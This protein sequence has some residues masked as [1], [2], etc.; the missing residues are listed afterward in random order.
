MRSNAYF[1]NAI[2]NPSAFTFLSKTGNALCVPCFWRRLRDSLLSS[3][4]QNSPQD[5]FFAFRQIRRKRLAP[6]SNP[7]PTLIYIT[8]N[9]Q[10]Q[11]GDFLWRRLRDSNPRGLAPKRFSR[12]PRYDRFDKPPCVIFVFL[13]ENR[14]TVCCSA[15][16]Y[17]V[18]RTRPPRYD[19]F[20]KPPQY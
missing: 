9:R 12:P 7:S 6:N 4:P 1:F 20:D 3:L 2:S 11:S 5:C 14:Y 10:N 15:Y 8:K 17:A 13:F 18:L 19:R 16:R